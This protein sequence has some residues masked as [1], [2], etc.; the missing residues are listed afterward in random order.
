MILN[1]RN[2]NAV[3]QSLERFVAVPEIMETYF[4]ADVI[5]GLF[6]PEAFCRMELQLEPLASSNPDIRRRGLPS[7]LG[8]VASWLVLI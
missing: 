7:W 4:S 1:R 3:C 6:P 5:T 8:T 2:M